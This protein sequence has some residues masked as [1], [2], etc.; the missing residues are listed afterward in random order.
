MCVMDDC[1]KSFDDISLDCRVRRKVLIMTLKDYPRKKMYKMWVK[2][3]KSSQIIK[4]IDPVMWKI[5]SVIYQ[6]NLKKWSSKMVNRHLAVKKLYKEIMGIEDY[7][8][9]FL[10]DAINYYLV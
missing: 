1:T 4:E 6:H 7:E 3:L 10:D 2:L 5:W 8:E 9:E